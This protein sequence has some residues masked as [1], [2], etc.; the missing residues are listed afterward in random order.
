MGPRADPLAISPLASTQPSKENPRTALRLGAEMLRSPRQMTG[1]TV[2]TRMSLTVW[3]GH[4]LATEISCT[5]GFSTG[6]NL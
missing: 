2:C 4:Q 6:W 5:S 3:F 1:H